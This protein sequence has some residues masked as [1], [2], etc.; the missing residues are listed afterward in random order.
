[1]LG[2]EPRRGLRID[3]RA[4]RAGVRALGERF[5][6][7]VD[8]DA[9]VEDLPVGIAQ[10]VELL[11]EL[12]SEPAVLI[13]DEP[14]AVL[15]PAEVDA[16]FATLHALAARGTAIM[17]ITH[18]LAEVVRHA[19]SVVVLRAGT[20][21]ARFDAATTDVTKIAEAMVGGG[22]PVLAARATVPLRPALRA[23]EL[24]A[25]AG[26]HALRGVSFEA[27][28]GEIVGIAGV[29]GNGQT[30][31]ADALCGIGAYRGTVEL[32]DRTLTP[33]DPAGHLAAGIRTIPQD[34]RREG[35]VASWS[36]VD[37]AALGDQ[38]DPE[39]RRGPLLD[40]RVARARATRI[41][42]RF[43]VRTASLETR[44][45]ALS[46]GNQQKFVVGRA[47]AHAPVALVAY[48]PTRGIDVAAT[49]RVRSRA[50][51]RAQCRRSGRADLVRTR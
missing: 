36:L 50:D 20:I 29:E 8:P 46:G 15:A 13:L 2:R 4:A 23:S 45:G 14:T 22:I 18:K 48:Q 51:R 33:S 16:L 34:R 3:E 7:P 32:G 39:L 27:R 40:R 9:R 42:E 21:V 47:L 41:V 44:A 24:C 5:G 49:A 19:R 17:V 10:R 12:A 25:G 11:R 30:A 26:S 1:M 35:L 38:R 43:D 28:A 6:L 37:N 31:L